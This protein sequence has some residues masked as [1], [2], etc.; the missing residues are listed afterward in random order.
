MLTFEEWL[1]LSIKERGERY[2]DLS[3]EDKYRA[4]VCGYY[5]EQ[6]GRESDKPLEIPEFLKD[7]E[8]KSDSQSDNIK[9]ISN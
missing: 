3:N 6:I 7:V 4:R 1:K 5:F 2:K 9:F 8:I